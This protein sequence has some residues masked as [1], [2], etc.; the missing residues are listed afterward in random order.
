MTKENP[1]FTLTMKQK[2]HKVISVNVVTINSTV[3]SEEK[4]SFNIL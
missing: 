1:T 3:Q 4:N 2:C